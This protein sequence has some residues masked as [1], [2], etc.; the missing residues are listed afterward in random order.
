MAKYTFLGD[1]IEGGTVDEIV[2][3]MFDG[4]RFPEPTVEEY[5]AGVKERLAQYNGTVIRCDS[6]S[7][8]VGDLIETGQLKLQTI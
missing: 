5:M 1:L 4:A 6:A 7:V 8:F 3:N 2:Q